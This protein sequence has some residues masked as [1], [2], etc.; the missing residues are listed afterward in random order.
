MN[1]GKHVWQTETS[2]FRSYNESW[3]AGQP[4]SSGMYWAGR[5]HD[6]IV[7]A[8]VNAYLYWALTW[9]GA[10]GSGVNNG[11]LTLVDGATDTFY[12]PKRV[13]AFAGYSRYVRPG[14]TRIDAASSNSNL[15]SSAYINTDGSKVIVVINTASSAISTT[16][17]LQNVTGTSAIPHLTNETSS[18]TQQSSIPISGG[19]FT[20]T[21]PARSM[22]T[23]SIP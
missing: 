9:S 3:D 7:N 6:A 2:N 17:A 10:P 14:A 16:F 22:V 4:T 13:W 1:A 20:A 8:K 21:V 15:L 23:Y 19:A 5:I 18:M 11:S 12:V